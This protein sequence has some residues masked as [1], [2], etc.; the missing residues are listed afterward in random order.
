MYVTDVY[1]DVY[2]CSV[3]NID[4]TRIVM[5]FVSIACDIRCT[6]MIWYCWGP[7]RQGLEIAQ[8]QYIDAAS[9]HG[10]V[11]KMSKVVWPSA[12]GIECLGLV[13]NGTTHEVGLSIV[14]LRALCDETRLVLLHGQCSGIDLSRLVDRCPSLAVLNAVYRYIETADHRVFDLWSTVRMELVTLIGSSFRQIG[15]GMVSKTHRD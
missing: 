4:G 13:V 15:L 5:I 10:L 8:R 3:V 11:V 14:K 1:V 9:A 12:D 7:D 6:L 2:M